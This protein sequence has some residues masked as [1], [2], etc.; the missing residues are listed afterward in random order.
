MAGRLKKG[1]VVFWEAQAALNMV[2]A[3]HTLVNAIELLSLSTRPMLLAGLQ[4][5]VL[6]EEAEGPAPR[7]TAG[8]DA[9]DETEAGDRGAAAQVL[10]QAMME[11]I[12][13]IDANDS[14]K[15][16]EALTFYVAVLSCLSSLEVLAQGCHAG[17]SSVMRRHSKPSVAVIILHHMSPNNCVFT[18]ACV[19]I[20]Y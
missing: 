16:Q 8:P 4:P 6:L 15:T 20:G 17:S 5:S 18:L 13:A 12:P 3:A 2:T 14:D 10:A 11:V 9:P 19:L 7:G 1:V